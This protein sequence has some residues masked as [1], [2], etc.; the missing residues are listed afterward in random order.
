MLNIKYKGRE[1]KVDELNQSADEIIDGIKDY[2]N[3]SSL[4][5]FDYSSL[6]TLIRKNKILFATEGKTIDVNVNMKAD[7]YSIDNSF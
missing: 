4:Y 7:E 1:L 3:I 6:K 5:S 2:F